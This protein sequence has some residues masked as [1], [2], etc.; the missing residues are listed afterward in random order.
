MLKTLNC[1]MLLGALTFP[2]ANLAIATEPPLLRVVKTATQG[3]SNQMHPI[4]IG[5]ANGYGVTLSFL[6]SEQVIT[7]AWLDNPNFVTI[8]GDGCLQGLPGSVNCDG[9]GAK[10][11]HL[12]RINDLKISGLPATNT[13]LLTVITTGPDGGGIYLY[14]IHKATKPNSLIFEMVPPTPEPT[15]VSSPLI[16]QLERGLQIASTQKNIENWDN[17]KPKLRRV[18]IS[19]QQGKNLSESLNDSQVSWEEVGQILELGEEK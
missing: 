10:V 9:P 7:K 13:S 11:L 2:S 17:L 12:K 14:R 16:T 15:P 3:Q 18:V 5:L 6:P 1:L 19:L 4:N 8:D